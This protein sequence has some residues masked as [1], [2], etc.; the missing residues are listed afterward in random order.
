[1]NPELRVELHIEA[2]SNNDSRGKE[3]LALAK[4]APTLPTLFLNSI[5]IQ[6]VYSHPYSFPLLRVRVEIKCQKCQ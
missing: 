4:T 2:P 1:M 6:C 3:Q 5:Y